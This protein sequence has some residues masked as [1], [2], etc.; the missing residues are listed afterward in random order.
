MATAP[1]ATISD[2]ARSA[3]VSP[4]AVSKVLN[5]GYGVS[6]AMRE[7]VTTAIAEL[8]YRPSSAARSL[9]G[10]SHSLGVIADVRSLSVVRVLDGIESTLDGSALD[11]LIGPAG[12]SP[13]KQQRGVE[14]MLNRGVDGLILVAPGLS[15]DTLETIGASVPMVLIGRHGAGRGFDTVVDDDAAGSALAV[16]HLV[17]LGHTRIAHIS[18]PTA[19]LRRPS[20][21]PQ[22]ARADGYL[23]AMKQH[24]I[25]PDLVVT[26]YTED[27]GY[28]GALLAI[29]RD[30][31]ATAIFAGTDTVA[32]GV[33]RAAH[34]RGLK[35]PGDLSVVGADNIAVGDLPQIALTTIDP[36]GET[37]G[38]TAAR[39]LRERIDGRTKPITHSIAPSLIVRGTTGAPTAEGTDEQGTN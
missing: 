19:G 22:T 37:N 17:G 10:R 7:K 15:H 26:E 4:A 39:L 35:V 5:N 14:A 34:E 21:L 2:V 18:M 25:E 38:A 30:R 36:S 6:P 24:G 27:G 11:I 16:E 8:G 9:R 32:L 31:P 23:A 33:L 12:P 29:D 20:V 1:R 28:R 3:G 13:E